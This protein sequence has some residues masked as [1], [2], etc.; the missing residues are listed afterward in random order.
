MTAED[1]REYQRE[2]RLKNKEKLRLYREQW[3]LEHPELRRATYDRYLENNR[4]LIK[5][6]QRTYNSK[7]LDKASA[8]QR[9]Y[10]AKFRE[11]NPLPEKIKKTELELSVA[12]YN[13]NKR[14]YHKHKEEI[15][16]KKD[17]WRK[18][19]MHKFRL[20]V[21]KRRFLK[22]NNG[23]FKVTDQDISRQI[24]RQNNECFWCH[25][26]L[27]KLHVDH[28]IP[29]TKGGRHSIGNIVISCPKC[30]LIK[31]D[32]LPIEFKILT[33]TQHTVIQ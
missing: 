9:R 16:V 29:L 23:V 18:N 25:E 13:V 6:H 12:R 15:T 8:R 27:D 5:E 10:Y 30:N 21:I 33:K 22:T 31:S 26:K 24:N 17:I 4:E 7:N 11:E 32:R 3:T 1:R 2:Y 14:Y 20:Y 19:N 28:I